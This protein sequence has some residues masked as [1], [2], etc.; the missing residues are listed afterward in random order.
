MYEL[1]V[2]RKFSAAHQLNGY[3]GKCE[4]LHGHT[5]GLDVFIQTDK[6]DDIG[7]GID[8]KILKEDID[9][10]LDNYDHHL[11]N[12]VPPFDRINPSAENMAKVF[13]EEIGKI[14]PKGA[15][16]NKV[17]IWESLDAGASYFE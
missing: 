13:Y 6:L 4:A 16:L 9:A 14:V 7:L 12:E 11:I 2:K 15:K 3:N 17:I 1:I 10:F 8:F 5:Y